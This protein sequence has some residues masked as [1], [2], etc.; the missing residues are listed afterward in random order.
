MT[1]ES[2]DKLQGIRPE[3]ASHT[4]DKPDDFTREEKADLEL[5][6]SKSTY[7]AEVA[8]ASLIKDLM[9]RNSILQ[10]KLN[11]RERQVD[12]MGPEIAQLRHAKRSFRILIFVSA[13]AIT[14]GSGLISTAGR[15]SASWQ[16]FVTGFGWALIV[17][18][19]VIT[20]LRD[21]WG[22]PK[23]GPRISDDLPE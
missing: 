16:D 17:L 9:Q 2:E 22:W 23:P 18:G 13:T 20:F 6:A 1:S 15:F 12:W 4:P 11:R 8:N 10:E 7:R 14:V 19:L 21:F 5:R 3:S